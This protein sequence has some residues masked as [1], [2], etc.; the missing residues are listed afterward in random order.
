V[1]LVGPPRIE[2]GP[3][4]TVAIE[5]VAPDAAGHGRQTCTGWRPTGAVL[6]SRRVDRLM[7]RRDLLCMFIG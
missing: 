7:L 3:E 1:E 5:V 2:D 6:T 4:R